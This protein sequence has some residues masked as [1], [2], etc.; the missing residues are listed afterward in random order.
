[1]KKFTFISEY[2]GGTYISQ[3]E[4]NSLSDTLVKWA[5]NLNSSIYLQKDIIMLQKEVKVVDYFP[6][7]IESIDNV[8]CG[9][10][11]SEES[12]LL[13]NIIETV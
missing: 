11:L 3:F 12:F 6:V 13:L 10:F 5:D 8:W 1:M 9:T 2:K 7:P 4:G